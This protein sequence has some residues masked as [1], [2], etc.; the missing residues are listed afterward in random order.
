MSKSVN[1]ATRNYSVEPGATLQIVRQAQ[2][3]ACLAASS[4]FKIAFDDGSESDFEAGLTYS[5]ESGFS[6]IL[7]RNPGAQTLTVSLGLGAGAIRDGRVTINAGVTLP[8]REGAPDVLS[9]NN[10]VS[11]SLTSKLIVPKNP[12]RREIIISNQGSGNLWISG[13]SPAQV[14]FGPY[15]KGDEKLV[16]QTT[17]AIYGISTSATSCYT[18]ETGWSA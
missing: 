12:L 2:F 1:Y 8:V 9:A 14:N 4:T 18:W 13:A 3:V 16:L 11:I 17:S 5:P 15:L 6:R 10:L 7:I